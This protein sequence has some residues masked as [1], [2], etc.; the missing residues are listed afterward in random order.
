MNTVSPAMRRL[1][2]MSFANLYPLYVAKATKKGRTKAEVDE[3]IR[4]LTGYSQSG[5]ASRLARG[6]EVASFIT[7]APRLNPRRKLIKGI[8]C[9]VKV[10]EIKDPT[11]Q[12]IRY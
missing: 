4:W 1:F 5:L 9:G 10:E 8:V 12:T 3:V 2:A 6:T 7:D 11:M